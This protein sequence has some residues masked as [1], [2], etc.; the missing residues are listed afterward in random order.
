ML[1]RTFWNFFAVARESDPME[2]PVR[3]GEPLAGKLSEFLA[4]VREED[5][6]LDDARQAARAL[7][8]A[9]SAIGIIRGAAA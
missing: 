6:S 4:R 8:L 1:R 2:L 7:A 9:T 3:R 5:H